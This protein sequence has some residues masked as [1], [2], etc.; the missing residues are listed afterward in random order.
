MK[1][2]RFYR[3]KTSGWMFV[4]ILLA[5]VLVRHAYAAPV[6]FDF[7][8]MVTEVEGSLPA[9]LV[10]NRFAGRYAFDPSAPVTAGDPRFGQAVFDNAVT[11]MTFNDLES[12]IISPLASGSGK[13]V[14]D[15]E[16]EDYYS[17]TFDNLAG[18]RRSGLPYA[19]SLQLIWVVENA[20]PVD[21][22]SKQPG[23]NPDLPPYEIA[24]NLE[25]FDADGNPVY[26]PNV[27][28]VGN[29]DQPLFDSLGNPAPVNGMLVIQYENDAG[30]QGTLTGRL[31]AVTSPSEDLMKVAHWPLNEGRGRRARD[32]S[33]SR[34]HGRLI[35]RP[36]WHYHRPTHA[37]QLW[38][39]GV[40]DY[41]DVG[42]IDLPGK[43][44][45]LT[46][47]VK[48]GA[49]ENCPHHDC[50]IIS[51]SYG[52]WE[53][54]HF[55]MISTIKVDNQTR[56]RFQLKTGGV[57]STLIASSGDLENN[58]P[59]HVAAV[60][61][62]VYMLL[63]KDGVEVGRLFKRGEVDTD[64]AVKTWIGGNPN[65]AKARPWKGL[66]ADVRIYQKALLP[67]QV[68]AVKDSN[69]AFNQTITHYYDGTFTEVDAPL[70][71]VFKPG[72][73]FWGS[74]RFD[75]D[76]PV[77]YEQFSIGVVSFGNAIKA[78]SFSSKAYKASASHGSI[79]Y[80]YED[81]DLKQTGFSP[82]WA[83]P[84]GTYQLSSVSF[85]WV[86]SGGE[87][88]LEKL[89]EEP[90]FDPALP[91][92]LVDSYQNYYDADGQLVYDTET[93]LVGD[94]NQPLFTELGKRAANGQFSLVFY[95]VNG[96][97]AVARGFLNSVSKTKPRMVRHPK[98]S[99]KKFHKK[100]RRK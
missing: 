36:T 81:N 82:V 37:G 66:I 70:K 26:D 83:A 40:D 6:T 99:R 62:G 60:Y 50:R 4:L 42:T 52:I 46:A 48:P 28:L 17:V 11:G 47:W 94:P 85:E 76:A 18:R 86:Q 90:L 38:F 20:G 3:L 72:G 88:F 79:G 12:G 100:L 78:M 21:K 54:E 98:Q 34:H 13:I 19:K 23:F 2:H 67:P 69:P 49:L 84:V 7:E 53:K 95:N 22:L 92:Y 44:L 58:V 29:P 56:L 31:T 89:S 74:Y 75:P 87:I 33:G 77:T 30:E 8:G 35:N 5:G 32:I 41:V 55:W 64:P 73:K 71:E 65:N 24:A 16:D 80:E 63:Y 96:E 91:P 61:N 93:G 15:F 39:D 97:R 14:H 1:S 57:T 45:T 10:G 25:L 51:K 27:G 43:A 59:F 9:Y 68:I